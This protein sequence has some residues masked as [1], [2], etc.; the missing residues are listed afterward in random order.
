MA[1]PQISIII[2]LCVAESGFSASLYISAIKLAEIFLLNIVLAS[3]LISTWRTCINFIF[4]NIINKVI[5]IMIENKTVLISLYR[6]L[7]IIDKVNKHIIK[8]KAT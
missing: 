8:N 6:T 3:V 4:N 5:L 7:L 1:I 2:N